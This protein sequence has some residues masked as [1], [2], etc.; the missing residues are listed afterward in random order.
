MSDASQARRSE[1]L[2][3]GSAL[4]SVLEEVVERRIVLADLEQVHQLVAVQPPG[5][6]PRAWLARDPT[7]RA[8]CGE[9]CLQPRTAR[10]S[11]GS[12]LGGR[13][14]IRDEVTRSGFLRKRR[15]SKDTSAGMRDR[16][17]RERSHCGSAQQR[18]VLHRAHALMR[19][20]QALVALQQCATERTR[21]RRR[22]AH[23]AQ[24]R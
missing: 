15:A 22:G 20:V 12:S 6:P 19:M 9:S 24:Q 23:D 4:A 10:N 11:D 16:S 5:A 8:N 7:Q 3:R 18:F 21:G 13:P 1:D 17:C 2:G 14:A